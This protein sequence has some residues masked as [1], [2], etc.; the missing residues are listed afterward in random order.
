[1][2]EPETDLMPA[3]LLSVQVF[4]LL[5]LKIRGYNWVRPLLIIIFCFSLIAHP[6]SGLKYSELHIILGIIA[7]IQSFI[8]VLVIRFL[9]SNNGIEWFK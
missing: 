3:T 1:M 4:G 6:I 8:Q 5:G 7:F 2:A 9:I